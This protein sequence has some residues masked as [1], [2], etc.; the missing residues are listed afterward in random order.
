MDDYLE[1]CPRAEDA[2]Q[3]TKG[4]VEL[5]SVG[6]FNLS[7]FV[8]KDTNILQQIELSSECQTNDGKLF[9]TTEES[10]HVL[11]LKWNHD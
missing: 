5:L 1:S 11:V 6:G 7:K 3:K 10:S 9:P 4:L 8:P 2:T